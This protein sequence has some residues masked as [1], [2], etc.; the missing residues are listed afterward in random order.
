MKVRCHMVFCILNHGKIIPTW[1]LGLLINRE[2]NIIMYFKHNYFKYFI[3]K[4]NNLYLVF[5][6]KIME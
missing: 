1:I 5:N 6:R 4:L 2:L 3:I